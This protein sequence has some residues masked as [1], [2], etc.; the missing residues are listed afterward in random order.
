MAKV[1]ASIHN[2]NAAASPA[3]M[4]HNSF[5]D[6]GPRNFETPAW[7]DFTNIWMNEGQSLYK[8]TTIT[9]QDDQVLE[10]WDAQVLRNSNIS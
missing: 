4:R 7:D 9:Y 5:Y 1:C 6:D 3:Q 8:E 2:D 10:I